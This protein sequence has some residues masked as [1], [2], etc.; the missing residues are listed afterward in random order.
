[1]QEYANAASPVR[2]PV[3]PETEAYPVQARLVGLDGEEI[4]TAATVVR[5]APGHVMCRISAGQGSPSP[6]GYVRAESSYLWL[7]ND[8]VQ[9]CRNTS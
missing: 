9:G 5:H 8:D 1:M 6:M 7:I 2:V 4:W 3:R